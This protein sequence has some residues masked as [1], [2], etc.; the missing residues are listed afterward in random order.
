MSEDRAGVGA[1]GGG[2]TAGGRTAGSGKDWSES[3][4]AARQERACSGVGSRRRWGAV[5]PP[6]LLPNQQPQPAGL[7]TPLA[8][9]G[10]GPLAPAPVH[11]VHA[12]SDI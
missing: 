9:V 4:E 3:D 2:W 1:E 10:L 8:T 5:G 11:P 6:A 12:P 7:F